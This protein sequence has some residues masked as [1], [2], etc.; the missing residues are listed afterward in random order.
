MCYRCLCL[1]LLE[2][3]VALGLLKK[4]F[5]GSSKN[6][7]TDQ[8]AHDSEER[9]AEIDRL[10]RIIPLYETY[11]ELCVEH[12]DDIGL[13]PKKG[14][15]VVGYVSGVR[16]V[17]TR[18]QKGSYQ[19]GSSGVSLR[20]AKGVSYRVG[21]QKGTFVA[22]PEELT[23]IDAG[24]QFVVSNIRAVYIGTRNTKEFRWDKLVS[25]STIHKDGLYI[26][27]MP[28]ENRQRVSGIG[29]PA[30][31]VSYIEWLD[32][33]IKLGLAIYQDRH[34]EFVAHM[35]TDLAELLAEQ[36]KQQYTASMHQE[37]I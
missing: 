17:E 25:L 19:G 21:A 32:E 35:K 11:K 16:L 8:Q 2:R 28:V 1:L 27:A 26:F 14:E 3:T 30:S 23:V 18:R 34:E 24:G 12:S 20:I 13:I 37:D 36:A 31:N 7:A 33:R 22:G 10:K 29:L 4:L 5:R 6:P 15:E 9:Q